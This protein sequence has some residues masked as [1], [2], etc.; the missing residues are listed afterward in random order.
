MS[1]DASDDGPAHDWPEDDVLAAGETVGCLENFIG[2][3][4]VF[5]AGAAV[6]GYVAALRALGAQFGPANFVG[7]ALVT[8]SAAVNVAY[9]GYRLTGST[10]L[11]ADYERGLKYLLAPFNVSFGL[12]AAVV[13]AAE[14]RAGRNP[15]VR[16][17]V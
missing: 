8:I 1:A 3:L 4:A 16:R 5:C 2:I 9:W 15:A 17:S 12:Y 7:G 6:I 10:A 13:L 14:L 11:A